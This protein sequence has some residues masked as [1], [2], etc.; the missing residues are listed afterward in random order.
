[1]TINDLANMEAFHLLVP[2][3]DEMRTI[4]KPY[5]C[6]LLSAAMR[7]A[8]EGGAWCTV[9][10]NNN[11]L[12][13]AALADCSCVILCDGISPQEEVVE[14]A[15]EQRIC[16]FKTELPEFEAALEVYNKIHGA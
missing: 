1:M 2:A 6:D 4:T 14:K 16:L 3:E 8:P 10:N 9:M 11:T 5:C 7:L 12:A 13:V 15:K